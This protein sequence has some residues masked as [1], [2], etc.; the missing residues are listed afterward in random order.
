M[1]RGVGYLPEA[2]M[3]WWWMPWDSLAIPLALLKC[4][5]FYYRK[6]NGMD[7]RLFQLMLINNECGISS[8]VMPV[9][10]IRYFPAKAKI[11]IHL[12]QHK[13]LPHNNLI[14]DNTHNGCI[15][16]NPRPK[17][18]PATV[19]S[20]ILLPWVKGDSIEAEAIS[21]PPIALLSKPS[22][23]VKEKGQGV[24]PPF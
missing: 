20:S 4:M 24:S 14:D 10:S 6:Y 2:K 17:S 8:W 15:F 3:T 19:E 5:Q 7:I 21:C 9:T 22:I 23:S 16:I 11:L 12:C 1:W 18:L 13:K